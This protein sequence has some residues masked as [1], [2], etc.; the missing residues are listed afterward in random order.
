MYLHRVPHIM[1]V[2]TPTLQQIR[3]SRLCMRLVDV[4]DYM[5]KATADIAGVSA[6]RD[7]HT[8]LA[9]RTSRVYPVAT[10][11]SKQCAVSVY[12]WEWQEADTPC[13][14]CFMEE[15]AMTTTK[16]N[17]QTKSQSQTMAASAGCGVHRQLWADT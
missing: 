1:S 2:N 5:R 8:M 6:I 14:M 11:V 17:R 13:N 3:A 7:L 9:W 4:S 15:V 12:G 16:P 10:K